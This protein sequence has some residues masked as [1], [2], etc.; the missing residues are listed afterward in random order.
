MPAVL[1]EVGSITLRAE[2]DLL[3][4]N[5][6]QAAVADGLFD[7]VRGFF[8]ERSLA[9]RVELADAARGRSPDP[10]AG[11]GPPF[12]APVVTGDAVALRITNTGTDDWSS[13]PELVIGWAR[14]DDPYLP[15]APEGLEPVDLA[16]PALG[17]G[18]SV[19]ATVRLDPPA[20]GGRQVA[21]LTLEVDGDVLADLGSPALQVATE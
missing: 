11:S 12:W 16:L 19:V 5:A 18:E 15:V 10:V 14:S 13:A 8:D 2:Q 9:G 6:G 3:V 20:A 17:V 4:T 1:A 7:A 21:W